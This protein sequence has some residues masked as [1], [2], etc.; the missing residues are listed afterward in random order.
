VS[1]ITDEIPRDAW[2][3][4]FDDLSKRL[5][6]VEATVEVDGRDL[7]AQIA[8]ERL[9]LEGIT[10][11]DRDD[12]LVVGFDVPEGDPDAYEHMINGPQRIFVAT[13]DRLETV[14]D[15]TD[16]DQHQTIVRLEPPPALPPG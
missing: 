8:V 6:T 13:G 15:V 3:A 16:A 14:I 4:Y 11:D 5:R 7:G 10:Y 2:R 12:L 1:L 9:L